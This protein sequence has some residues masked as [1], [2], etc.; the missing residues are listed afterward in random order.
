M[1]LLLPPILSWYYHDG[2]ENGRDG[3]ASVTHREEAGLLVA[4]RTPAR[5]L[6]V[7]DYRMDVSHLGAVL[8]DARYVVIPQRSEDDIP[9]AIDRQQP[10]L[11]VFLPSG[12]ESPLL[13]ICDDLA[14]DHN[15]SF[16]PVL[17]IVERTASW[18]DSKSLPQVDAILFSPFE[19]RELLI[20]AQ[21][22]LRLKQRFDRLRMANWQLASDLAERNRQLETALQAVRDLDLLKTSIVRNVSHEL[23]TPVLQVKSA[24]ALLREDVR[25]GDPGRRLIDMAVEAIG[26]LE[27]TVANITQ[28][29][30]SQNLKLEPVVAGD[31]VLLAIRNLGRIWKHRDTRR[32]RQ[33]YGRQTPVVLADKRG[34][35]QVLQQL[36]DNALKFSPD[37]TP[38]DIL[39]E[40][41]PAEQVW[42]AV[43]DYGIGIAADQQ[44]R[45]FEAFYQ[46][47]SSSTRRY[48]G[49]GLGLSIAQLIASQMNTRIEVESAPGQGSTFSFTL[50]RADLNQAS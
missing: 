10:D 45:I 11:L 31:C 48:G 46:V 41:R 17:L 43:R 22:L 30:E 6:I 21:A 34:V 29:A 35:A 37:G 7:Y 16:V 9:A 47:D 26:R 8:R 38:I 33:R 24:V 44:E 27:S 49:V 1:G 25:P 42:I 20:R 39:I 3:I 19:A 14:Q 28:L 40:S 18:L 5:I 4:S 15:E 36:L 13:A 23:R 2:H 32:V 12:P 50:P